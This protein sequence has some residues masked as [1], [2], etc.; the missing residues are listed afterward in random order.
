MKMEILVV[1]PE[2]PSDTKVLTMKM[3]I[4][5]EPTSN[6]LLVESVLQAGN[7]CQGESSLKELLLDHKSV[8]TDPKEYIKMD[9]ETYNT[10]SATLMRTIMIQKGVSMPV[11]R[12]AVYKTLYRLFGGF[13][14]DAVAAI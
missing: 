3:E 10:A 1:L 13:V 14:V 9:M 2:H 5:L 6:K 11:Q 7:S 12:I 8:L 4:L